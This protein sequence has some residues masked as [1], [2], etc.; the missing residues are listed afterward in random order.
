MSQRIDIL[1]A[2][3]F[4][5][6]G[7]GIVLNDPA[8]KWNALLWLA[9][10]NWTCKAYLNLFRGF[11]KHIAN[12]FLPK[13]K[14]SWTPFPSL[15]SLYPYSSAVW[16]GEVFKS[17]VI[18]ILLTKLDRACTGGYWSLLLWPR[19]KVELSSKS[20]ANRDRHYSWTFGCAGSIFISQFY[21]ALRESYGFFCSHVLVGNAIFVSAWLSLSGLSRVGFSRPSFFRIPKCR[22]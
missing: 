3:F 5:I 1:L 11:V 8:R 7:Q 21:Y 19:E 22:L 10:E 13:E 9:N 16:H 2:H 20:K 14:P 18:N 4:L 6:T 17:C 15:P 12:D